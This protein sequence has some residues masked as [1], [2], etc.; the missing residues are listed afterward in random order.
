MTEHQNPERQVRERS[1]ERLCR[2]GNCV[3]VQPWKLSPTSATMT[4][5]ACRWSQ[6]VSVAASPSA[7]MSLRDISSREARNRSGRSV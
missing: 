7:Y 2:V 4:A 5:W 3:R 1:D 6:P